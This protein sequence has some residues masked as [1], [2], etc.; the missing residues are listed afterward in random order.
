MTNINEMT[1]FAV[2]RFTTDLILGVYSNENF[3]HDLSLNESTLSKIKNGEKLNEE[4][5]EFF[6]LDFLINNASMDNVTNDNSSFII[7]T[8]EFL[9]KYFN[10][11]SILKMKDE[12]LT[13]LKVI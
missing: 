4:I 2:K 8:E 13:F 12:E 5:F 1:N 7:I 11:E 6:I 9:M 10:T 3:D